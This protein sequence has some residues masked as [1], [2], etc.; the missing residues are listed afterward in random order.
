MDNPNIDTSIFGT[1]F[2]SI[3]LSE[4]GDRTQLISFGTSSIF[5][6]WGSIVG[7]CLALFCSCLIGVYFSRKVMKYF[8]QKLIDFILGVIFL[9]SGIQIFIFKRQSLNNQTAQSIV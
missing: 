8:S 2:F 1:I 9:W 5:H 4:F 6:F 3:C 7:S